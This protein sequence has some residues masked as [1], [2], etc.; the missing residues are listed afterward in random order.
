LGTKKE[1]YRN[2]K[3]GPLSLRLS[4]SYYYHQPSV[5]AFAFA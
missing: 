4:L 1:L 3:V 2:E 5:V